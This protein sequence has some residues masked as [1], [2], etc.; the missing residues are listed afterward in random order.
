M[1]GLLTHYDAGCVVDAVLGAG[2]P[3]KEGIGPAFVHN[4]VKRGRNY[5]RKRGFTPLVME[6]VYVSPSGAPLSVEVPAPNECP[7]P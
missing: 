7:V 4:G 6:V 3:V 2:S 1:R 5:G